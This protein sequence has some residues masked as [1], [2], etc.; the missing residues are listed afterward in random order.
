MKW[1]GLPEATATWEDYSIVKARF[2]TANTWGQVSFEV[3]GD[4]R[5]AEG[6]SEV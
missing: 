2:P 4:V 6:T 5:T 3:W 1:T